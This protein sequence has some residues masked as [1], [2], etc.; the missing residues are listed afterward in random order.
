MWSRNRANLYIRDALADFHPD[1]KAL[2][3]PIAQRKIYRNRLMVNHLVGF[4]GG[5]S[6]GEQGYSYKFDGT[7]D[8]LYASDHADWNLGGN[9]F[10]VEA[11][12]RIVNF[13][14]DSLLAQ[15]D[16]GVTQRAWNMELNDANTF[17]FTISPDGSNDPIYI[18]DRTFSFSTLT[19]YHCMCVRNGN[20]LYHFVDGTQVGV[21]YDV[22][23]ITVHDSTAKLTIG[24]YLNTDPGT[25]ANT[26]GNIDEMRISDTARHT[27]GF[28]PPT[29]KYTSD[30][31]TKL[32]I[33]CE[34]TKSGTTGSGATFTDSG[35]T[36]HTITE[37]GNAIEDQTLGKFAE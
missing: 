31:N 34:E 32:L 25:Y 14:N 27:S 35:N 16:G 18:V 15:Y 21:T 8:Y 29:V 20:N 22:T 7:G 36:G 30:A 4:G 28:T 23:G 37:Y 11:W 10:T 6:V 17:R 1:P 13:A 3:S 12:V 33:H 24:S 26:N 19:W 9:D 2:P 5:A